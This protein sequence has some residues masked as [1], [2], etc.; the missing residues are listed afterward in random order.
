MQKY[1]WCGHCLPFGS[2]RVWGND[3][4]VPPISDVLPN[5]L[6]D[7]GLRVQIIHGNVKESLWG[8]VSV[9]LQGFWKDELSLHKIWVFYSKEAFQTDSL[10]LIL[11]ELNQKTDPFQEHISV[12]SF[13]C[14]G[15]PEDI[16]TPPKLTGD[17]G[18][19]EPGDI[20]VKLHF[21]VQ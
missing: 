7:R 5:P 16:P 1:T 14:G 13:I 21:Q 18:V 2:T 3:D 6:Q 11:T 9:T 8:E 17:K 15:C 19:A 4:T 20:N 10:S 12:T